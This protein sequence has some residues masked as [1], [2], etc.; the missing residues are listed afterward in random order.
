MPNQT[1]PTT[2]SAITSAENLS[3]QLTDD[4]YP[5]WAKRGGKPTDGELSRVDSVANFS[6]VVT[7]IAGFALADLGAAEIPTTTGLGFAYTLLMSFAAGVTLF[8]AV[9]GVLLVVAFQ[10]VVSWDIYTFSQYEQDKSFN[11]KDEEDYKAIAAAFGDPPEDER[12]STHVF[13]CIYDS[14]GSP[15]RVGMM[16]FPPAICSYLAAVC[17]KVVASTDGSEAGLATAG[18][19]IVVF[20]AIAVPMT[21]YAYKMLS[22]TM[23]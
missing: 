2:T 15:L 9:V 3:V 10:R 12:Y 1:T 8:N 6:S 16:L 4:G 11:R 14:P 19:P 18:A 17:C 7:F 5:E 23:I 21:Y 13:T 22:L 20:A